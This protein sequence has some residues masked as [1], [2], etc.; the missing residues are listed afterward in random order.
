[1]AICP[2]CKKVIETLIQYREGTEYSNFFI[3]EDGEADYED[4]I[5]ED[6]ETS[7][8]RC[9]ECQKVLFYDWAEAEQFLKDT[10]E[11][12]EIIVEKIGQKE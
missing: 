7:E 2:Y 9:V 4:E 11:L 12:Q 5:F 8:Y 10:D 6:E 1:M 3:N